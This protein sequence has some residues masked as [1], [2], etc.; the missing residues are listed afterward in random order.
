MKTIEIKG[1][2]Y[3]SVSERIKYLRE[4]FAGYSLRTTIIEL[5]ENRV[6]MRVDL[7]NEDDKIVADGI[8]YEE[9]NSTFINK[10]SY[11]E[12]CQTSAAGRAL[13]NFGIGID[14]DVASADE[15]LNAIKQNGLKQISSETSKQIEAIETVDELR[16]YYKANKDK[17]AGISEAF[18]KAITQRKEE[19]ENTKI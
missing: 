3:V 18:L 11:I 7:I 12:N 15:I 10:T 1:K 16:E 8:A 13:G 14:S 19:I 17:N 5:N 9:A 2:Q 4:N 6:V